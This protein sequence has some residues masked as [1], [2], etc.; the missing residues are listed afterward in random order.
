MI[1]IIITFPS[2]HRV[3]SPYGSLRLITVMGFPFFEEALA[4]GGVYLNPVIPVPFPA[5]L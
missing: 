2:D 5:P 3:Y 1:S 4:V